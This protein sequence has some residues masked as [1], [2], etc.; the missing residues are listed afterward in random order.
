MG[1][2][3]VTAP[4]AGK[5]LEQTGTREW[6]WDVMKAPGGAKPVQLL[7]QTAAC[8]CLGTEVGG[9]AVLPQQCLHGGYFRLP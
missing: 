1:S 2:G 9:G 8:P 6:K 4:G 3:A 5:Y 7:V